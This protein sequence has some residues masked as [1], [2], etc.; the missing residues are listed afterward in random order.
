MNLN[1]LCLTMLGNSLSYLLRP[2]QL[3][4]YSVQEE[5]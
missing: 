2:N 5:D 1:K 4:L 3:V